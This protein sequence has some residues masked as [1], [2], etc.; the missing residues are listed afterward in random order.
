[1]QR[2]KSGEKSFCKIQLTVL[3]K[4][5]CKELKDSPRGLKCLN[6][7]PSLPYPILAR[8]FARHDSTSHASLQQGL[9]ITQNPQAMFKTLAVCPATQSISSP[10]EDFTKRHPP[11]PPVNHRLMGQCQLGLGWGSPT[12]HLDKAKIYRAWFCKSL[13]HILNRETS[14]CLN[15][16]LHP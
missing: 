2:A 15:G 16:E 1:M 4:H 6:H 10:Y 11:F 13:R 5:A 3:K 14:Q 8:R 7:P 12:P 9:L